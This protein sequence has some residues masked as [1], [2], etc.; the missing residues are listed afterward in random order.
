MADAIST[1]VMT[2][3]IACSTVVSSMM[4]PPRLG[5]GS[6]RTWGRMRP[7]RQPSKPCQP[8]R[9]ARWRVT[10]LFHPA[11]GTDPRT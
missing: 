4:F 6:S 1:P 10:G 3:A 7:R 2:I 9:A 5:G 8:A 11:K